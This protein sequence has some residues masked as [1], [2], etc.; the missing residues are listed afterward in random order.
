MKETIFEEVRE[1]IEKFES[2]RMMTL[3]NVLGIIFWKDY[4]G[5]YISPQD[6]N[7]IINI[8]DT[9]VRK[10]SGAFNF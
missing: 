3:D 2:E 1:T 4:S 5:A 6:K 8:L 7:D 10:K 9:I